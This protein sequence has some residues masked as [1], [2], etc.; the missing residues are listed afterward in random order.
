MEESAKV[1]RITNNFQR[2]ITETGEAISDFNKWRDNMVAQ[3]AKVVYDKRNNIWC[4]NPTM[5][6]EMYYN[7]LNYLN[8]SYSEW[9]NYGYFD[10]GMVP[11][12]MW[13][14]F[15]SQS[16]VMEHMRNI[17]RQVGITLIGV[18]SVSL[19]RTSYISNGSDYWIFREDLFKLACELEKGGAVSFG[20]TGPMDVSLSAFLK[21]LAAISV[22]ERSNV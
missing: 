14:S 3:G 8:E 21:P 19:L 11:F 18:P 6:Y 15:M 5:D 13:P 10:M 22:A 16:V 17:A 2:L 4:V 20:F 1:R 7:Y 12:M 9:L